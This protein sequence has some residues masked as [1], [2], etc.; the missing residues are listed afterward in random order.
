MTTELTQ[1]VT[2][3]TDLEQII[4]DLN[5]DWFTSFPEAAIRAAQQH[6]EAIT[7]KL[8]DVLRSAAAAAKAGTTP[9]GSAPTIALFLIAEFEATEALPAVVEVIS[10]PEDDAYE[11][12]GDVLTEDISRILA[13]LVGDQLDVIDDLIRTE[14]ICE[15]VRW[16]FADT[17]G[18]LY[19]DGRISRE[20]GLERLV[21]LLREAID[22]QNHR[23]GPGLVTAL[24][25]FAPKECFDDIKR[26]YETGV[27]DDQVISLDD[28][29]KVIDGEEESTWLDVASLEPSQVVDTVEELESWPCFQPD[30]DN[31]K[32]ESPEWKPVNIQHAPLTNSLPFHEPA[33]AKPMPVTFRSN[34]PRVGRNEPCPCNS[35]KKFKKCCG[36][37]V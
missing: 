15:F 27:A 8:I 7:P 25:R 5:V 28:C 26:A 10:L 6:R 36:S 30:A 12:F 37:R 1:E 3:E 2:A 32:D 13:V 21:Q 11:L 22:T 14:S 34:Q 24:L 23:I 16:T 35:G 4:R 20:T 18:Q 31:L 17:Y 19:R 33:E 29:R 9:V